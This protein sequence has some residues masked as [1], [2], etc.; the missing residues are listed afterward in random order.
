MAV[1]D[2]PQPLWKRNVAGILDFVL[3]LFIFGF[4]VSKIFGNGPPP[5]PAM[6]PPGATEVFSLAGWPALLVIALIIAYF[7]VLGRTGGTIFQRLF[8]MKRAQQAR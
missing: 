1:Y 4:V 5:S 7:I 2:P 6:K 8:G 3:A